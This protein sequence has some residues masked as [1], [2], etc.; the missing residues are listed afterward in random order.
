MR[1]NSFGYADVNGI[2][3]YHEMYGAGKPLVLL[4]GGLVTIPAAPPALSRDD[5][6]VR[7][8]AGAAR[9][10]LPSARCRARQVPRP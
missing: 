3:L 6:G 9:C 7:G 1:P 2:G 5:A 10:R 8:A 4:H